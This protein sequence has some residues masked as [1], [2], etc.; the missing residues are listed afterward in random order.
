MK[1]MI[2]L[3]NF[4]SQLDAKLDATR[5]FDESSERRENRESWIRHYLR[6]AEHH[7]EAARRAEQ[8]AAT[9][10]TDEDAC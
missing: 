1:E 8:S 2:N 5:K 10:M 7:R 3:D 9:L 4:Q 6:Q